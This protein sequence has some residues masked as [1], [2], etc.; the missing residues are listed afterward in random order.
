MGLFSFFKKHK[1]NK[2]GKIP[3]PKKESHSEDES[4]P[5]EIAFSEIED[6]VEK[7]LSEKKQTEKVYLDYLEK[8]KQ[9]FIENLQNQIEIL[10]N[11]DL[12]H[13]KAKTNQRVKSIVQQNRD[14]YIQYTEEI[15][16][17]L[18]QIEDKN[19]EGFINK[20]NKLFEEFH[21]KSHKNY[22]KTT[23]LIGKEIADIK[24]LIKNFSNTSLKTFN[25][26]KPLVQEI[27]T[28]SGIKSNC[29]DIKNI[30]E[31]LKTI[32]EKNIFLN[33][34]IDE[35][36]KE[37]KEVLERIE[38][39]KSSEKYKERTDKHQKIRDLEKQ[40]SNL[41]F[42]LKQK[43]DFKKMANFFHIF[44]EKIKIVKDYKENFSKKFREDRQKLVELLSEAGMKNPEISNILREIESKEAEAE[45]AKKELPEDETR[46][47]YSK[48]DKIDSEIGDLR[49][50]QKEQEKRKNN[51]KENKQNLKDSLK[52]GFNRLGIELKE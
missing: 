42:D 3:E 17:K 26:N 10:R 48:L 34:K 45:K 7:R 6:F 50:Q 46:G 41:I 44:P 14:K 36:N 29:P 21:K 4:S 18:R 11:V 23:V 52:S 9:E 51:L 35:K 1:E 12:E 24:G 15:I 38:K 28:L 47:E 33:E 37:R 32:D 16:E 49:N 19:L 13:K 25:E 40:T 43:I 2:K 20:I 39:I 27:K 30:I 31:D 22:E 8:K 5:K